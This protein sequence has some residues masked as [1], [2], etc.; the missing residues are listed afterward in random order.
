MKIRKFNENAQDDLDISEIGNIFSDIKIDSSGTLEVENLYL[1]EAVDGWNEIFEKKPA[2]VSHQNLISVTVMFESY[3]SGNDTIALGTAMTRLEQSFD[4]KTEIKSHDKVSYNFQIKGTKVEIIPKSKVVDQIAQAAGKLFTRSE[5]ADFC[6]KFFDDEYSSFPISSK[7]GHKEFKKL[8]KGL[9]SKTSRIG[10]TDYETL[11]VKNESNGLET[12][13]DFRF[14][15]NQTLIFSF[16][17]LR[18]P[19]YNYL[20]RQIVLSR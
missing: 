10:S 3:P 17:K 5:D 1:V 4:F 20:I 6:T 12:E 13:F 16:R 14:D 2:F 11:T 9:G 15:D 8:I 19:D 18:M 7:S